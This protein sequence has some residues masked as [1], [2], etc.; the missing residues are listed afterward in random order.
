[1]TTERFVCRVCHKRQSRSSNVRVCN[2][3]GCRGELCRIRPGG[4][5]ILKLNTELDC[6]E[7]L[8]ANHVT[9]HLFSNDGHV[10]VRL[11]GVA[12]DLEL[13]HGSN[14]VRID[15]TASLEVNR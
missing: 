8:L 6:V 11:S 4:N 15:Y 9:V 2:G 1:M 3:K 10:N 14:S 13:S 5:K 12:G 7:L